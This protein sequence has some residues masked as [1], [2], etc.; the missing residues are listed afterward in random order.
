MRFSVLFL[1]LLVGC[2][3]DDD[4]KTCKDPPF[5]AGLEPAFAPC[6]CSEP[7]SVEKSTNPWFRQCIDL[8]PPGAAASVCMQRKQGN[9]CQPRCPDSGCPP[10][11]GIPTECRSSFCEIPC[12]DGCPENMV[13]VDDEDTCVFDIP[14]PN[15][16]F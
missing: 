3:D 16:R 15:S 6:G 9:I 1:I 8:G 4:G 5:V 10:F 11:K 12:G 7:F 2:S 13:C 14:D